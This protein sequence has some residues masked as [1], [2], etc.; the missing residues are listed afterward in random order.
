MPPAARWAM[1]DE[2]VIVLGTLCG[3]LIALG[4]LT[5]YWFYTIPA[6]YRANRAK[7]AHL[8]EK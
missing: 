5:S 3:A 2:A 6:R 7:L 1:A 4:A 8:V